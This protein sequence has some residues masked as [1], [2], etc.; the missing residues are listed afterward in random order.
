MAMGIDT[1]SAARAGA[2]AFGEF[3]VERAAQRLLR[4]GEP[5]ALDPRAWQVLCYLV[6][7]AGALVTKAE[8]LAAAWDDVVVSDA[9][10]SQ[11][12]QRLRRALGDPARQPRY[13]ETVHGRGLRF[14]AAIRAETA[15]PQEAIRSIAPAAAPPFV[16]RTAERRQLAERLAAARD[17]M[18]Q[19]VFIEGEAGIGKTA[20]L[21]AFLSDHAGG[22]LNVASAQCAEQ[23]GQAEP[24]MPVLEALD[25]LV[26]SDRG[27]LGVLRQ[28]APTWLA[29]MPWLLGAS[30]AGRLG[31]ALTQATRG[32]MLREMVHA[33]DVAASERPLLLVIEDLHWADPA[34]VDLLGTLARGTKPT[35]LLILATYRP[36][37]AIVDRHPAIDLARALSAKRACARLSLEALSPSEVCEYLTARFA[38]DD[39]AR[40]LGEALH[41]RSEGN[42]LYLE[43]IVDHWVERGRLAHGPQGWHLS[44]PV[45]PDELQ[46]IPQSLREMIELH[47]D[48]VDAAAL[49]VLEA[50]SA[51]AVRFRAASVAAALSQPGSDG[52]E[53]VE[54]TCERLA[55]R[56]HLLRPAGEQTWPDGTRTAC[57]SLS[58]ELYRQVLYERLSISRRRRLHQRIG[59]R[60]EAAFAPDPS[61]VAAELATL[62]DRGGDDARAIAYYFLAA[63]QARRRFAEREAGGLLL[64]ALR[65]IAAL[66]PGPERDLQ[67][68]QARMG[69][70]LTRFLADGERPGDE[71]EHLARIEALLA[72]A[73]GDGRELFRLQLMLWRIYSLR[74]MPDAGAPVTERLAALAERGDD[75]QR[76][77]AH[78]A[79]AETETMQGRFT[80]AAL[81]SQRASAIYGSGD[82]PACARLPGFEERWRDAGSRLH[83][84]L[85]VIFFLTGC[86]DRALAALRQTIALCAVEHHPRYAALRCLI[87]AGILC[88]RGDLALAHTAGTRGLA[89]AEEHQLA[90]VIAAA[91]PQRLWLAIAEGQRADALPRIRGA[92]QDYLRTRATSPPPV[93]PLLLVDACRMVGAVDEG[94]TIVERVWGDTRAGGLRWYD[95]ELQRLRG[96]LLWLRGTREARGEARACVERA[97][98]C[99]HQQGGRLYELR[100]AMSLVRF[101][102]RPPR[103]GDALAR[104]ARVYGTFS[105]GFD[106]PDL[107]MAAKLLG[108]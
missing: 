17:G 29:Q 27:M 80:T 70:V 25:Q 49:A 94:L 32:R 57:Y 7:H 68:L 30:E 78:L 50:A 75:G 40:S 99:A 72:A 53:A 13:I 90:A 51:A 62:C 73:P 58:H 54:Q 61:R 36:A 85:G 45:G 98:E 92:W 47:V 35:R 77:E 33:V 104:L 44:K 42:P 93:A 105:E 8:I 74:S 18:R 71:P 88:M 11:A 26:Q 108:R 14:V 22:A 2:V 37:R 107:R 6:D 4:G 87:A 28:N 64:T 102:A 48:S 21:D 15:A 63:R 76:M 38:A 83:A 86:P 19:V 69:I 24:Y 31:D 60:L 9:A 46:D 16:G 23:H 1:D 20:L 106:T 56:W 34:T 10:L 41:A 96:E 81:H 101:D 5:V 82:P 97:L 39:L 95:A 67:E 65:R 59:E 66:P 3:R 52:I 103:R 100:A 91:G 89:I 79:S 84:H 55:R 12:L 43:T